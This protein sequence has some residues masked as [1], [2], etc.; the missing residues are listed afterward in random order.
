MTRAVPAE[1]A[2]RGRRASFG[3]I[4]LIAATL[5]V[6]TVWI[7]Q[8]LDWLRPLEPGQPA[9]PFALPV[10][11]AGGAPTGERITDRGLRG[12]VVVLEFWATWCG[13]CRA[14]L[15]H[16]DRAAIGWGDRA[17]AIAVNLDD[18]AKARAMFD[19]A[20]YRLTLTGSDEE[21]DLRYGVEVLPH[22]VVIDQN[23]VVRLV[24]SGGQG[25]RQV[26]AAVGRLLADPP[27]SP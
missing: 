20:G 10:L 27:A 24:A 16:L 6:N 9:P 25:V 5:A 3:V 4:A 12:K 14:S 18:P 21:L 26:Q 13:P 11:G 19:A 22:L 8:H 23:G 1:I 15:P 7:A 2:V 17:A